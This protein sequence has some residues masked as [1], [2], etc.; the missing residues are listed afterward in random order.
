MVFKLRFARPLQSRV[1]SDAC[2]GVQAEAVAAGSETVSERAAS[3][4]WQR[5]RTAGPAAR[6]RDRRI[7]EIHRSGW[8]R[9]DILRVGAPV[10]R[11]ISKLHV[12]IPRSSHKI[13]ARRIEAG[14]D[15]GLR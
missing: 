10:Q 6:N 14:R 5:C 11:L 7:A 15:V 3:L 9:A 2:A 1:A 13:H 8:Q 4:R 12:E